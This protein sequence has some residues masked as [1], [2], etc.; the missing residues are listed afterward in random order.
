[1]NVV[2]VVGWLFA[3]VGTVFLAAGIYMGISTRAF[4]AEAVQTQ[5]TVIDI[6]R[7]RGDEGGV[8][9]AP[10]VGFTAADGTPVEFVSSTSS[11]R[12]HPMRGDRVPV[13]YRA[14]APTSARLTGFLA[15]WGGATIFTGL[16]AVLASTGWGMLGWQWHRRRQAARLR[17]HG[18]RVE[19]DFVEVERNLGVSRNGRHPYRLVSQWQDPATAKLHVFRSENLW[20]D[21]T[22]HVPRG[23]IPVLIDRADPRR[24]L[25]DVS[26]LPMV[27]N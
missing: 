22:D 7:R 15:L 12:Q 21:P 11:S 20:F 5:G 16:G 18:V 24:H 13:L 23:R 4:L 6:E 19:T 27:A 8:T 25:M 2:K 3:V 26:F 9:F 14:D 1:M 10:V 17:A